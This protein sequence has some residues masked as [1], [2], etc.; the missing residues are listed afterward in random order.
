MRTKCFAVYGVL[1][2]MGERLPCKQEVTGSIP[3]SS[4]KLL[5]AIKPDTYAGLTQLVECLPYK[6][7]V[8]GSSPSFRTKWCF[9]P[10]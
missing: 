1:A 7:E 8:G 5:A 2:Q 9:V 6:E 10:F 3:V 4:T